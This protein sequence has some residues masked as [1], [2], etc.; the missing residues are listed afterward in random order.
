[1]KRYMGYTGAALLGALILFGVYKLIKWVLPKKEE[2]TAK[3]FEEN[4]IGFWGKLKEGEGFISTLSQKLREDASANTTD[5]IINR[6]KGVADEATIFAMK[7]DMEAKEE[8]SVIKKYAY[9]L[10]T[11]LVATASVFV[12]WYYFKNNPEKP[13][14]ASPLKRTTIAPD[15]GTAA[16]EFMKVGADEY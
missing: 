1:M 16:D 6:A 9:M 13:F 2:Q 10:L 12:Y 5:K 7:A 15:P 14:V 4:C 11:G 8:K 3:E